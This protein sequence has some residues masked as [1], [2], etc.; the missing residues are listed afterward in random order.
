MN[1]T[2]ENINQLR[3]LYSACG[4]DAI[5]AEIGVLII[6][7]WNVSEQAAEISVDLIEDIATKHGKV[8]F[9]L[10]REMARSA[11]AMS[12]QLTDIVVSNLIKIGWSN[13][14][15]S[16]NDSRRIIRVAA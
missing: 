10:P 15:R 2:P 14:T 11:P 4:W 13:S 7:N 1:T 16:V 3:Q 12:A 9:Y 6:T 5:A 8:P